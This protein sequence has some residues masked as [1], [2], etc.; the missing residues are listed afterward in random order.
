MAT[1]LTTPHL[2]VMVLPR[3]PSGATGGV[4]SRL[5]VI[6]PI[7]V[8]KKATA[9]NG[10]RRL[11]YDATWKI[12]ESKNLDCIVLFKP[13]MLTKGPDTEKMLYAELNGL[14]F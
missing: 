2:R 12:L 11:V 14:V 13:I 3:V 4:G 6:V 1:Q 5:S 7:K 10:F 9:R 8:N